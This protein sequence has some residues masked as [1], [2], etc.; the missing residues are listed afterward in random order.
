MNQVSTPL[1]CAALVFAGIGLVW[2]L[3]ANATVVLVG[4]HLPVCTS[5]S[6]S[7]CQAEPDW[8]SEARAEDHFLLDAER[9]EAWQSRA[10]DIFSEQDINAWTRLLKT[11]AAANPEQVLSRRELGAQIRQHDESQLEDRAD[12]RQWNHLFDHFQRP[13]SGQPEQVRLADSQNR[14]AVEVFERVVALAAD[15]SGKERPL[16]AVSTASARDPYDAL[17]FYLQAFAQAGAEVVWLPLD[18]AVRAARDN[19]ACDRLADYQALELGS[20]RRDRV[21]PE[22][23]AEQQ[24]FCANPSTGLAMVSAIDGLFINGGD[25]WLTL[26]AFRDENSEP[27][28][29]LQR[30]LERLN[31]GELLIGGTSAGAAVQSGADMISN[32][33][34]LAALRDGAIASPPPPPG[35]ERSGHCPEGLRGDSLTWHPAGGL[36]TVTDAIVD[37]HFSERHRQLR[38]SRLLMD[39]Q[40]TLGIGVDET[41]ALVLHRSHGEAL[42]EV[43]GAGAAWLVDAS[44]AELTPRQGSGRHLDVIRNISLLSLPAGSA[45]VWPVDMP[46]VV[47]TAENR[48]LTCTPLDQSPSFNRWIN[49]R[50]TDAAST[51][52]MSVANAFRALVTEIQTDESF[53]RFQLDIVPDDL[54]NTTP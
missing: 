47:A 16:I 22:R 15:I 36:G 46:A 52:C 48:D 2:P 53:R 33:S 31:T 7:Q 28:P 21:W 26:H 43:V 8:P 34:N 13:I 41:T 3:A 9:I 19:N 51:R 30:L 24:V 23:F 20:F 4:G 18:A 25:Q 32:G 10:V 6:P 40:R 49:Q 44:Q 42:F 5:M 54:T 1:F 27:T 38:L 12:D 35:C 17:D 45:G 39:S 29:E 50:L 14:H 37:T 11:I